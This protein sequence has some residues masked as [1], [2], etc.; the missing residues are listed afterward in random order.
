MMAANGLII[1]A[2]AVILTAQR[3]DQLWP[4]AIFLAL[5]GLGFA[6]TTFGILRSGLSYRDR[7][8]LTILHLENRFK[9]EFRTRAWSW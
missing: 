7:Y 9:T 4:L 1:A 2:I 6:M 3:Y 8:F 5:T